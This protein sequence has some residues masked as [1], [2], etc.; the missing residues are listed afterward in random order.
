[1]TEKKRHILETGL[2]QF[3]LNGYKATSTRMIAEGANVSEGL[4]FRHFGSKLG[5]LKAIMDEGVRDASTMYQRILAIKNPKYALK[6]ILKLPFRITEEQ[7]Y[8]W[9]LYYSLKWQLE[10]EEKLLE[11]VKQ[12][13][14]RI[15][16]ELE[17]DDP[18]AEAEIILMLM[19]GSASLVLQRKPANL[20]EIS[21]A[22]MKKYEL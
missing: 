21:E 20:E 16:T 9:R 14:L 8:F 7:S 19:N 4:I 13:L 2:K 6:S 18:E 22:L 5:L 12:S 10:Y 11:P 3:A 17:Y 1:M 15:F